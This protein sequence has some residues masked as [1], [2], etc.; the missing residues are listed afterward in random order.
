MHSRRPGESLMET[1]FPVAMFDAI[2]VQLGPYGYA[3]QFQ[4][5][6]A[7]LGGGIFQRAFWK[8]WGEK[9]APK[10]IQ[11]DSVLQSWDLAFKGKTTSVTSL[12]RSGAKYRPIYISWHKSVPD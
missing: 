2:K 9:A 3:S 8:W 7:P 12:V 11:F 4:Q 6:P 5:R 1:R 10:P